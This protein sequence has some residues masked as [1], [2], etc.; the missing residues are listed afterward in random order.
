VAW[1]RKVSRR[2]F[3]VAAG[4][5][6]AAGAAGLVLGFYGGT[7][8]ERWRKRVPDRGDAF[9]P[10]VFLAVHPDDGVTI[11]VSR[12]EMGQGVRT[13]LPM[14]IAEELDADWR[15]VRIEQPE[16]SLRYGEQATVASASV[17]SLWTELRQAGASARAMLVAAAA[18]LWEVDERECRADVG[19]VVHEPTSRRVTY[20]QLVERAAKRDVP[21][22]APLKSPD[23]FRLLGSRIPRLDVPEKV[24]GRARFGLDVRRPEMRYATIARCP[25]IG[26]TLGSFD[27]EKALASPGVRDVFEVSSGVAIV[28]DHTWAAMQGRKAL[29]V[30]WKAGPHASFSSEA[31]RE[32]LR[33]LAETDGV[34]ASERGDLGAHLEPSKEAGTAED[35]VIEA[36]YEVPYLAHATM[37]PINCTAH[38]TGG[39][40]EV[41]APTQHPMNAR[42]MAA[43]AAGLDEGNVTLWPTLLGGG[44]GRRARF[45][46]VEEVVEIAKR[47][48]EPTQLVWSRED[49]I[50]H[51]FYRPPALH[52]LRARLDSEG[53]PVAWHDRIVTPS[54]IGVDSAEGEVDGLAV[55]GAKELAYDIPNL[56][57]EW[58]H[59]DFPIPLGIWRSVGHSYNAYAVEGFMDELA[60]R[61]GRD[62]V[63]YRL[64]L[65]RDARLKK[66]LEVAA[67]RSG[68]GKALPEGRYR[69]VAA[70]ACFGSYAAQ[71]AEISIEDGAPRVHR[72]VCA[73]DCGL[74]V[75]PDTIEAQVEGGIV[76]GLTA[77]LKGEITVTD[78]RIQ[79]SNFHDY[80]MLRL[81]ETPRVETHI[82][83]SGEAPGGIGELSV[84]QIAP[85]VANALFQ[86]TGRRARRLPIRLDEGATT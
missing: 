37:E 25:E 76:F 79:Q 27:A 32:E 70:H 82:V 75:N 52:R 31:A 35:E 56:R 67:D 36:D 15:N 73:V 2:D 17:R 48:K 1:L 4:S 84:P 13:A 3:L 7:R 22:D 74:T 14:I 24:D 11:W 20:G 30:E 47:T 71:V 29:N 57:V 19:A 41:W 21:A 33:R 83:R 55:D 51:D 39:R 62:P 53:R 42:L 58:V 72:V 78:G 80:E 8:R 40:C 26:G 44:F 46:E 34:V 10:N 64:S 60:T 18:E 68:W 59:A 49:D 61:A 23:D 6:A 9:A 69:G 16:A 12:S 43:K 86:A 65:L 66:V 50:Q 54:L 81:P 45:A 85:A 63:D 5:G 28:A 38:V 77:A